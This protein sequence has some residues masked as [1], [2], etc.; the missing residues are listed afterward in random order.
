MTP[1]LGIG[2]LARATGRSIH[3]IRW[4]ERMGLIPGVERAAGG[5]RLYRP[6][7]VDWLGFLDRLQFT[8]LSIREMQAYAR[9]VPLGRASV[10]ERRD[11]LRRHR[12][13][14]AAR[15][16]ELTDALALIDWK[17]GFYGE[18]DACG[19]RPAE[20]GRP[21]VRL[22]RAADHPSG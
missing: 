6:D 12:G 14:V 11:L 22:R 1:R 7:H 4:Y 5:R 9:L 16:A 13:E 19:R 2:A 3:A 20:T 8:G 21:P 15:L 10:G 17:I 18:W